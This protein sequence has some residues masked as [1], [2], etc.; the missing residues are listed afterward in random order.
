MSGV[1]SFFAGTDPCWL[2]PATKQPVLRAEVSVDSADPLAD[3]V[4]AEL[5]LLR[6]AAGAADAAPD[7]VREILLCTLDRLG[8]TPVGRDLADAVHAAVPRAGL[9]AEGFVVVRR[10]ERLV[11][12]AGA[13][14]GLLYGWYHLLRQAAPL[15][16]TTGA[17][18]TEAHRP[19]CAV[20]MVN[21]WDNMAV[22]PVMGSV[23]RG[24]AGRSF[25]YRDGRVVADLSRVRDY[26]RLLASV[27]IN[28][29][30]V[31]NVNVHATETRLL[32]DHL[33]DL[34][35]IADV[36][37]EHG[38][39]T[40][41]SVSYAAPIE[42][43]GLD[44]A[45]PREQRVAR[46]WAEAVERVYSAIPDLGGFVVKAD[47]EN[48]PG[49]FTYGADHADGANLLARALRPHGGTVYWR[50]F[51]YDCHQDWRDRSTDRARA[52]YDHFV[53][54]DGRF[55]DNV[56]LQVKYGPLDFQVREAVSPLIGALRHT[57]VALELQITQEYTG[58]QRHI[59]Y[60]G[61]LWTE[62]LGFDTT[63]AGGPTIGDIASGRA[64][65]PTG[66]VV[67]VSNVGDDAN[68]T[69]HKLAQA[70]LFAYG[71]LA[72]DPLASPD[73]V[74]A[75]WA[76]ATFAVDAA[77]LAELTALMSGSLRTYEKYTAPLGVGF[78][79]TPHTHYGPSVNGY[80]YSP[81]GTYHFADRDGVG[82]DRTVASG[83]GYTAQYPE[84]LA[85]RYEDPASCPDELLL[86]FHH[87]PYSHVLR[88]GRTVIQ[89]IYDTHFDGCDEVEDLVRRWSA[90]ADRF[91]A[92]TRRNVDERLAE[93]LRCAREWRDQV[94]TY[95]F[96]MSGV[97]DAE[98]RTIH[99]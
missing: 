57:R 88:S 97:P 83:S 85:S 47:S 7:G 49:P 52:A 1:R 68:W 84:P 72:W 42:L 11:I 79:V 24:Y 23:E 75:E 45:D 48:R 4:R 35:R 30:S 27:G 94:N 22:H 70:N 26:A 59:C 95:F 67:A 31:N 91:D 16:A 54:L 18:H 33:P 58:Q 71:R 25:F 38:I 64:G 82:V 41:L 21:Q 46:W 20:R 99:R 19:A 96:R 40:Y 76:R 13:G 5:D 53:P 69:G 6:Q 8:R 36:L 61:P 66:G 9:G 90:I 14:R 39:T 87:V 43:G 32:T 37:R 15:A 63:G 86:F 65:R 78:M 60:L 28:A 50:C 73:E 17:D 80:E 93:Q 29:L 12:A 81:W 55:D 98:G 74:L 44:T 62:I 10:G 3:T 56:V 2:T 34:A 77:T 89:H 51:V 92:A